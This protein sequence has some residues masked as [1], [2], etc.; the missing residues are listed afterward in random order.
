EPQRGSDNLPA[1]KRGSSRLHRKAA[2]TTGCSSWM[3]PPG[4]SQLQAIERRREGPVAWISIHAPHTWDRF[5]NLSEFLR[6]S[7]VTRART[8]RWKICPTALRQ[9]LQNPAPKCVGHVSNM[10]RVRVR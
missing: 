10:P 3:T 4:T 7:R 5:S 8:D 9:L 2:K 6:F 1:P